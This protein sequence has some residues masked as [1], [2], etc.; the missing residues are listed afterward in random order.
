MLQVIPYR[1]IDPLLYFYLRQSGYAL[2][3]P[4]QGW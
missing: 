3:S 4:F 2:V 1:L